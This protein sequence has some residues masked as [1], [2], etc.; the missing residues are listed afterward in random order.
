MT[1]MFFLPGAG[2]SA[3]FWHPVADQLATD[4]P[5]HFFSWPGLGNEP[6][7]ADIRGIDDLVS[8]VITALHEPSDLIA[9]SMG[10]L[11]AAH[12]ALAV[13]EKIR[14][15]VLTA[16]SAGVPVDDLGGINWRP[17]Y[18]QNFPTA[19]TWITEA[20][21]DIS[22]KIREISAP[23][24]LIW[25]DVDPISPLAVGKRLLDLLPDA[26]LHVVKGGDHDLAITHA[27]EVAAIIANYL[28]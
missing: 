15:I 20:K 13:P 22:D 23:V 11:V 21:E 7:A 3:V 16:T 9:Q 2:A 28:R 8:M 17:G 10:G 12:V 4:Q 19:A 27:A 18:R 1:K 6:P 26:K 5:K 25:G 24:L 14:R